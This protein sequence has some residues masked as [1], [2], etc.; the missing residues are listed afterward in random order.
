[1][2]ELVS[3]T[4]ETVELANAVYRPW[5][6]RVSYYFPID[7]LNLAHT[8]FVQ[9]EV[10]PAR[11][12]M[13]PDAS[14]VAIQHGEAVGWVQAGYVSDIP[15]IPEGQC[16]AL[17]RCLMVA[18]GRTDVGRDLLDRIL[19][20]LAQRPVRAWR[21]FEHNSGYTFA[22]GI[23]KVPHRMTSV[24]KV[25]AERGFQ[26]ERTNLVYATDSLQTLSKGKDLSAIEVQILPRGWCEPRAN[27]QW[28]QFNFSEHGEKVG[29]AIVVP[30]RRLTGNP[31]EG[32]LFIKAI[33]VETQ[34][35]RR[36][37]GHLIVSTLWEYYHPQDIKRLVLNTGDE[38]ITAQK[39]Y[40]A[41]GFQMTDL[42][43]S[44][45]TSLVEPVAGPD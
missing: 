30:V 2:I 22:A 6:T 35:R 45:I 33:A 5:T 8:L 14:L 11:F 24:M 36:G 3:L 29:Y 26:P 31:T 10:H 43:S 39:F 25:L 34:H 18:H 1:M 44:F 12:E 21:A 38:N 17:L 9:P 27:V 42:I 7:T 15:T 32:A 28:D 13:Q 20:V 40:E 37:I 41:V 4:Y 16:D 19:E 23:G